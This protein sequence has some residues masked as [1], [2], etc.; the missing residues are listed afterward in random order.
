M[1]IYLAEAGCV[2][3]LHTVSHAEVEVVFVKDIPRNTATIS[4]LIVLR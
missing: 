3:W 1:P 2:Y 4:N